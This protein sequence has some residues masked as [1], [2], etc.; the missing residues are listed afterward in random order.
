MDTEDKI[1]K[2]IENG[3][4]L[5]AEKFSH[6]RKYFWKDFEFILYYTKQGDKMLDFGCGNGRFLEMLKD[7]KIDYVGVDISQRLIDIAKE[8]YAKERVNFQKISS[9]PTLP[10]PDNFFN[11]VVSISVFHHFPKKHA[12]EMAKEIYRVTKPGGTAIISVW[13]LWQRRY[14]KYWLNLKV[15]WR[16]DIIIPFRNNQGEIFDRF[17]HIFSKKELKN[18]FEK[19]GFKIEKK[20]VLNKKNIVIIGKK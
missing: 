12:E 2:D 14:W 19:S 20:F 17:H 15:I 7:K 1:L 4:D 8:K 13:N 10:F 18:I 5:M 16:K 6:T 9:S 11:Q 3:Y